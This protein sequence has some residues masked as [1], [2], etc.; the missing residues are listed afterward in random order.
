MALQLR[1]ELQQQPPTFLWRAFGFAMRWWYV[2][3]VT[4]IGAIALGYYLFG[5]VGALG[6]SVVG[7]IPFLYFLGVRAGFLPLPQ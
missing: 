1:L 6:G 3:L 5:L 7:F 2:C 4:G